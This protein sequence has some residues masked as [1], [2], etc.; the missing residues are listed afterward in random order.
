VNEQRLDPPGD[1]FTDDDERYDAEV[2]A[3][4]KADRLMDAQRDAQ[5]RF[6]EQANADV[7]FAIQQG[8]MMNRFLGEIFDTSRFRADPDTMTD[9]LREGYY[10]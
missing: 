10:D 3:D 9:H 6:R 1:G 2:A 8:K 7:N 5:D 4:L